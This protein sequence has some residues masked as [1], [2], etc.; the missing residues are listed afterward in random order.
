ME[1]KAESDTNVAPSLQIQGSIEVR[2]EDFEAEKKLL[3]KVDWHL[4]PLIMALY[5]VSFLDR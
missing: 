5:L 1:K 4:I 2:A 3:R